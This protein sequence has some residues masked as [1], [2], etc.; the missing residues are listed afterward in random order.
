MSFGLIAPPVGLNVYVVNGIAKDVPMN[1]TYRAVLPF[2][3]WDL[4]RMLLLLVFPVISLG[5]VEPLFRR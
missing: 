3:A 1:A 4:L 2:L 5:L